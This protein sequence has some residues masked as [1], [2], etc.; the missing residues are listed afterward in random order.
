MKSVNSLK[1]KRNMKLLVFFLLIFTISQINGYNSRTEATIH[2]DYVDIT[3]SDAFGMI[4]NT[5]NLF[6]LDVRTEEEYSIGHIKSSYLLPYTEIES[7][8]DELPGNKSE[9]ILVYC[10]TGRRSAIASTSLINLNFT[11]VYNMLEGFSAWMEANYPYEASIAD[12]TQD[13]ITLFLMIT[14]VSTL[15]LVIIVIGGYIVSKKNRKII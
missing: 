3:V 12:Q 5:S 4:E 1:K 7:R 9:P 14:I 6:I 2:A 10:R 15:G 13:L 11:E 8:Q